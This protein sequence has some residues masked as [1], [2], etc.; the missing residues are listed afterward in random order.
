MKNLIYILFVTLLITC[1]TP[2]EKEPEPVKLDF[3][4]I[5]KRGKLIALTGYN[6]Y[7]YFIYKGQPLGYEYE[8][9]KRLADHIGV[10]IEIKLV[11]NIDQMIKML[12]SGEGDLIAFNL[13]VTNNRKEKLAFTEHHNTT[14]QVLVQRKPDNW[15]K[16]MTHQIERILIRNPIELGG[17]T[18]IVRNGSVYKSR[19]ENLADEIGDSIK[20]INADVT[21]T[22][23]DLIQFVAEG[24]I[25]Y[26][27]ADENVA[28]LNQLYHPNIDYKTEISF[29]Q[30][31]AWA[32]RKNS[33]S[34]KTVID[35]WID[36]MRNKTEYY[37]I[38]NK[39]FKRR[40]IFRSRSQ[41]EYLTSV[42]GKL[43]DYDDQIKEEA[44]LIGWD[45]RMLA[46]QIYQ[47]SKFNPSAKSWAGAVGLMQLM[48]STIKRFKVKKPLDPEE[49]I[50]GGMKFIRS[51]DSYWSKFVADTVERKK[52]VLASYNIGLG[53][54]QDAYRLTAK[55]KSDSTKWEN[56]V[57]EFLLKKSKAR[58]YNDEVVKF[59]YCRGLE[60]VAYVR[61]ILERYRHYKKFIDFHKIVSSG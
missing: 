38:Y 6:A 57:E 8:L 17:K 55:F 31:I 61:Q 34:L 25:D 14:T 1:C 16:M 29:P 42:S 7:S 5:K 20:I 36:E 52:F 13:T 35:N 58:Y 11:R 37:V 3:P 48:P 23:D 9:V 41:I 60:T 53:H 45:W 54:I 22:T 50:K 4:E 39:Y 46:S 10:E 47:E 40:N 49:N 21:L 59:G 43:S 24:K 18:V 15:R 27:V 44:D 32:V 26:T 51:L 28:K 12:D 33:D 2:E 19:L 56:N 30:K